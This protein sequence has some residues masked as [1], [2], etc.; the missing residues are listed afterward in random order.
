MVFETPGEGALVADGDDLW[1]R[2]RASGRDAVDLSVDGAE[3]VAMLENED[4][5]FVAAFPLAPGRHHLLAS[6]P[7]ITG[8]FAEREV[9]VARAP[10]AP[11]DGFGITRS[12]SHALIL[13][14]GS[15]ADDGFYAGRLSVLTLTTGGVPFETGRSRELTSKGVFGE[16]TDEGR[17]VWVDGWKNGHG[18]LHAGE[19]DG[20]EEVAL[21]GVIDFRIAPDGRTIGARDEDGMI[22]VALDTGIT[23]RVAPSSRVFV[24]AGE[25]GDV[26]SFAGEDDSLSRTVTFAGAPGYQPVVLAAPV[27]P[28]IGASP[29]R[30]EAA[31]MEFR[32]SGYGPLVLYD[33]ESQVTA[34]PFEDVSG[35]AYS[36][37]GKWMLALADTFDGA[38]SIGLLRRDVEDALPI[39]LDGAF[40][41]AGFDRSASHVYAVQEGELG[42]LFRASLADSA[43]SLSFVAS[44]VSDFLALPDDRMLLLSSAGE[45]ALF[46]TG[47]AVT[48]LGTL[49]PDAPALSLSEDGATLAF[50]SVD[51]DRRPIRR[52]NLLTG[53][54][55]RL[56]QDARRP[57]AL[58]GG[59]VAWSEGAGAAE[60][61]RDLWMLP[62]F[63]ASISGPRPLAADAD[64]ALALS[65]DGDGFATN[66]GGR[67]ICVDAGAHVTDLG[68]ADPDRREL[69]FLDNGRIARFG[70]D[71]NESRVFFI[72]RCDL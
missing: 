6:L 48:A 50:T 2:V 52:V 14:R 11:V 45:L 51:G 67:A 46:E 23:Q 39:L 60:G 13:S 3:P 41:R 7:G 43:L 34:R 66:A 63:P 58:A 49:N 28:V 27:L 68:A 30:R 29:A 25:S 69:V 64:E 19:I 15:P 62:S 65:A 17:L 59:A 72:Q 31:L 37:S 12:G 10:E 5:R 32:E 33:F 44:D 57:V 24:F 35:F 26:A 71:G 36:S 47:G 70:I 38:A 61:T 21:R 8:A 18:T 4:D 20:P 16:V 9:W 1:V 42:A 22:V 56:G 53:A 55:A 40:V 54:N